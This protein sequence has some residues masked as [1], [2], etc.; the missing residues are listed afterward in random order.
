MKVDF[1]HI[2]NKVHREKGPQVSME[3]LNT[4]P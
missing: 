1:A 3:C 4:V 2:F